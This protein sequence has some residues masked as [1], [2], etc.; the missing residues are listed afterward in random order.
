MNY[1]FC[2]FSLGKELYELDLLILFKEF[3]SLGFSLE[4]LIFSSNILSFIGTRL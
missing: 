4:V 1:E 3:Y 2:L